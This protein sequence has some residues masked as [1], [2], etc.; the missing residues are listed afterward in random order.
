MKGSIAPRD[1]PG[2]FHRL[3]PPAVQTRTRVKCAIYP[4]ARPMP[5]DFSVSLPPRADARVFPLAATRAGE[6]ARFRRLECVFP[7]FRSCG[8]YPRPWDRS[9][10]Q[11]RP[12][13]PI[14]GVPPAGGDKPLPYRSR[15][16]LKIVF[17]PHLGVGSSFPVLE[18]QQYSS[19]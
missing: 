9:G 7:V 4:F 19:D 5:N 15:S 13:G 11:S 3:Q 14:W 17:S 12:R 16:D 10:V 6:C 18:I 1:R 2:R 8:V